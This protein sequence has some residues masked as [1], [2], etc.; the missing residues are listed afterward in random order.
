MLL[1]W[2]TVISFIVSIIYFHFR[3]NSFRRISLFQNSKWISYTKIPSDG[4]CFY[5]SVL[6]CISE[7]YR[8]AN[9]TMKKKLAHELR[10]H[11][12]NYFTQSVWNEKYKEV[13]TFE[14][15]KHNLLYEWAGNIEWKIVSDYL[16]I[17]IIIFRERDDSLYWGDDNLQL[18]KKVILILNVN[19]NHFE[20]IV[21]NKTYK[22]QCIFHYS[23]SIT[24][25][26]KKIKSKD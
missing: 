25:L 23:S 9:F 12:Y 8:H 15:V 3:K 19:D 4:S 16:D 20:P 14:D 24:S 26:I 17:Q 10:M 22:H 2:I 21:Y 6:Y 7:K 11:V 18:S 5:H 1:F 13:C